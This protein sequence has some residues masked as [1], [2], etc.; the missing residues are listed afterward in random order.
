M[1]TILVFKN[2]DRIYTLC[3]LGYAKNSD[4]FTYLVHDGA[5]LVMFESDEIEKINVKTEEE[6]RNSV[7]VLYPL[8]SFVYQQCDAEGR[9]NFVWP[10]MPLDKPIGETK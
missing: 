9:L 4:R 10:S 6:I 8:G 7:P 5:Y 1:V 3:E 2:G